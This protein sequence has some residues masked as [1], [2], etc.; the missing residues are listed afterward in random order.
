MVI[1]M[2]INRLNLYDYLNEEQKAQLQLLLAKLR[3]VEILELEEMTKG[4][5]L[6]IDEVEEILDILEKA[7]PI[8]RKEAQKEYKKLG[9]NPS[10]S[11]FKVR[12]R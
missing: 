8:I 1:R 10:K 6:T 5:L 9:A 2:D 11:Y 12:I 7:I 4:A 3:V